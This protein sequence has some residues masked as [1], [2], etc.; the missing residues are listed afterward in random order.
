MSQSGHVIDHANPSYPQAFD[1][2]Y[3]ETGADF[4]RETQ[5]RLKEELAFALAVRAHASS[6][7]P[8]RAKA[9]QRLVEAYQAMSDTLDEVGEGLADC[10]C[11]V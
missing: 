11:A 1:A 6:Q 4:L 3:T 9:L 7:T 5:A 10:E 2:S 8:K